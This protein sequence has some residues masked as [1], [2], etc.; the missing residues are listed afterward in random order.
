MLQGD[1]IWTRLKNET[2]WRTVRVTD[3]NSSRR[4][5]IVVLAYHVS[6][7]KPG[8][9]VYKALVTSTYLHDDDR[10]LRMSHQQTRIT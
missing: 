10:A 7:E 4:G 9:P 1:N 3:R 8:V 5:D 2:P 6:A